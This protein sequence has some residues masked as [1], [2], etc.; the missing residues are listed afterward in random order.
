MSPKPRGRKFGALPPRHSF[1]VNPYSA[2]RFTR[3]PHC[4]EA[5]KLRKFPLLIHV[6]EAGLRALRKTCRYCPDCDLIIAHR[7][8]LEAQLAVLF[9]DRSAEWIRDAYL[10]MGTLDLRTWR[11]GLREPLSLGL[12]RERTADFKRRFDIRS[13]LEPT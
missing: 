3:C 2:Q 7:D 12:I 13:A 11:Q 9:P 10:V 6:D 1:A 5:T 4:R 8:E